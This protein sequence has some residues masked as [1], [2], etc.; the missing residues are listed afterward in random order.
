MTPDPQIPTAPHATAT[1]AEWRAYLGDL[2]DLA[3]DQGVTALKMQGF[4]DQELFQ[5]RRLATVYRSG[6]GT[7]EDLQSLRQIADKL[8]PR[9][10]IV[11]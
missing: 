5:L 10:Q 9:C 7:V 2:L 6:K 3:S 8:E 11:T 4:T 1:D